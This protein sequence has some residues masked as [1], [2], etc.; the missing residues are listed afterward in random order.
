MAKKVEM[1]SHPQWP[2]C[3]PV[4][5]FLLH[6]DVEFEYIDITDGMA[7]MKKYLNIRDKSPMFATI[8]KTPRIGVPCIVVDGRVV[9]FGEPDLRD[10]K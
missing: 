1:F 4:K 7:N 6:N 8:R 3:P 10:V 9:A 2:G 5:E